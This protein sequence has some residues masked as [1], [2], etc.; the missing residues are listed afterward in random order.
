M[1]KQITSLLLANNP[2]NDLKQRAKEL[3]DKMKWLLHNNRNMDNYLELETFSK[4]GVLCQCICDTLKA[5]PEVPTIAEY[6]DYKE[7]IILLG[8]STTYY[9]ILDELA[10][11]HRYRDDVPE[12]LVYCDALHWM[13]PGRKHLCDVYNTVCYAFH[14]LRLHPVKD[15]TLLVTEKELRHVERMLPE[16]GKQTF[17]EMVRLKGYRVYDAEK[18]AEKCGMEYGAFRRKL[19]KMTGYTTSQWIKIE[20][21]R[22]VEH[23]LKN[24][25]HTLTKVAFMTGFSSTSNLNDFCK[26]YLLDTPGEIRKKAQETKNCT[27]C[28]RLSYNGTDLPYSG[29]RFSR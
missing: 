22:D 3:D 20:R 19:K 7:I 28:T 5:L 14:R 24:T 10:E 26:D 6:K 18:L 1:E 23:Y 29:G 21:A 8:L 27:L 11:Q 9:Q 17:V 4:D 13:R 12:L 25:N 2:G 16:L 15:S